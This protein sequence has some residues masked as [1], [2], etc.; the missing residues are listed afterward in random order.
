MQKNKGITHLLIIIIG[1][2]IIGVIFGFF[3]T[4]RDWYSYI[5]FDIRK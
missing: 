2:I 4:Q 3:S 5:P 1:I